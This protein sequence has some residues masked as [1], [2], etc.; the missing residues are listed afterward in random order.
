MIRLFGVKFEEELRGRW[1]KP[2]RRMAARGQPVTIVTAGDQ[3]ERRHPPLHTHPSRSSETWS[4]Q[5]STVSS[6]ASR[7]V[8]EG[9]MPA[10]ARRLTSIRYG[11]GKSVGGGG[12]LN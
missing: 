4:R 11:P 12:A 1:S 6:T 10:A 3:P 9:R 7:S 5:N 2:A 8:V